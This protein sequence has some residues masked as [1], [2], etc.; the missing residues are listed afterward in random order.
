[1]RFAE[2]L[3]EQH[4]GAYRSAISGMLL[5][6]AMGDL[7]GTGAARDRLSRVI[8]DAMGMGELLGAAIVLQGVSQVARAEFMREDREGMLQFQDQAVQEIMPRLE[9]GQAI[10]ELHQRTPRVLRN[11]VERTGAA[12][13]KLYGEG[14]AI[15]FARSAEI[16]VTDRVRALLVS[17]IREGDTEADAV[18]KI[19]TE[20]DRV[21]RETESWTDAY[22]RTVFRTNIAT[23]VTAGKFR[24]AQDRDVARVTPAFRFDAVGDG[25]TRSNHAAADGCIWKTS[26]PIWNHLAPP[27]GYQC[28]CTV[29]LVT[30]ADLRR[31]GHL[32]PTGDV[33]ESAVPLGAHPDEGFRH[34]PR[35]DL[36]I[37]GGAA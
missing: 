17:F 22:A 27:L 18:A 2:T 12:I 35:P 16:A 25:D 5:G 20:V 30:V 26:N 32:T 3:E 19:R 33:I 13:A 10:D 1:M 23:A 36:F 9:L 29:H 8:A 14:R 37:T 11:A 6:V 15:A 34:A 4:L 31:M 28:R 24:Q 7:V 21:R